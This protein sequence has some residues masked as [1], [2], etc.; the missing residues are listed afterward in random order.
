MP[1]GVLSSCFLCP[2]HRP[3]LLW[4]SKLSH[5]P[6]VRSLPPCAVSPLPKEPGSFQ[7]RKVQKLLPGGLVCSLG[8]GWLPGPLGGQSGEVA[9]CAFT[10]SVC[11]RTAAS[12]FMDLYVHSHEFT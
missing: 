2:V 11:T 9:I 3:S 10:Y 7:R 6:L 5:I 8:L 1:R 12:A 4:K